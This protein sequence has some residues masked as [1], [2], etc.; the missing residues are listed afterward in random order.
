MNSK[1]FKSD[2]K[3]IVYPVDDKVCAKQL[4]FVLAIFCH[5]FVF[6]RYLKYMYSLLF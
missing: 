6:K 4:M 3:C 5:L 1:E 2:A